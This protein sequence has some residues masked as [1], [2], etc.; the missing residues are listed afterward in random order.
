MTWPGEVKVGDRGQW[1]KYGT[2]GWPRGWA[3]FVVTRIVAHGEDMPF[4]DPDD[5][6]PHA[7]CRIYCEDLD[8][9]RVS[10]NDLSR[11]REAAT[12]E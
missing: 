11:F 3:R 10:W 4:T 12:K 1:C 8:N 2:R 5:D 7:E 6:H 9:G